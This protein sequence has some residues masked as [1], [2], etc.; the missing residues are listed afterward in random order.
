[1]TEKFKVD[2]NFSVVFLIVFLT[3]LSSCYRYVFALDYTIEY[4]VPCN[5]EERNCFVKECDPDS[6]ECTGDSVEDTS[7]FQIIKRNAAYTPIC[8]VNDERCNIETCVSVDSEC[9]I[10]ECDSNADSDIVCS[11]A[12]RESL[13]PEK[14]SDKGL[15]KD[16]S[17]DNVKEDGSQGVDEVTDAEIG[18]E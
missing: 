5:P 6:E 8:N 10:L 11:D 4:Q 2:I 17:A 7:Y 13:V 3:V 1:M 14:I 12:Y 16:E 9:V 15:S 18:E